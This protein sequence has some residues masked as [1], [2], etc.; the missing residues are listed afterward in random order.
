[1]SLQSTAANL[2]LVSSV[3]TDLLSKSEEACVDTGSIAFP[4]GS[5]RAGSQIIRILSISLCW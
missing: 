5:E 2:A 4:S 3:Y 1:M